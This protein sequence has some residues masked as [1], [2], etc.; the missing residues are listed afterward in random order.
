MLTQNIELKQIQ[1]LPQDWVLTPVI[2]KRP[3]RPN[4]QSEIPLAR[5]TI[6]D[7]IKNGDN[8]GS[9]NEKYRKQPTGVG[10]RFGGELL[11]ID[12]DGSSA[13]KVLEEFTLDYDLNLDDLKSTVSWTSGKE[14]RY[15]LLFNVPPSL[16]EKL[17]N[18]T[19]KV[20]NGYDNTTC[21]KGEQIEF[22]YYR[23]QSVIPPS[24]HPETG[25]YKWI[26]HPSNASIIT[27]PDKLLILAGIAYDIQYFSHLANSPSS[28]Y[29]TLLKAYNIL[30]NP[31]E[32]VLGKQSKIRFVTK[33]IASRL[34]RLSTDTKQQST[35]K[36]GNKGNNTSTDY[37][38]SYKKLLEDAIDSLTIEELYDDPHIEL[39]SNNRGRCPI[40]QG[41]DDN[42]VIDPLSKKWYCHSQCQDGGDVLS[43]LSA[44]DGKGTKVTG[45]DFYKYAEQV[46][47]KAGIEPPP[48]PK[49]KKVE[50]DDGVIHLKKPQLIEFVRQKLDLSYNELTREIHLDGK[51]FD[52]QPDMYLADTFWIDAGVNTCQ[53]A[54]LKVAKENSFHPVDVYLNKVSSEV[55]SMRIDNLATRYF[56]TNE[57]LYDV[58]I[59]KFL[60]GCVARVLDAGCKLDTA[61][62]LQGKQGV[63]KSTFF[64]VLAGKGFFSDSM[65]D[66]SDR[67]DLL[68]AHRCWI[69]E[70]GE[71]DRIFGKKQVGEVKQF[72]SKTED[73]FREPYARTSNTYQRRFVVCGSVNDAQ[74]LTDPTGDRRFWV[75]P[76]ITDEIPNDLLR[77]ERDAIWSAAVKAYKEGQ[78]WW[79]E[80]EHQIRSS[81]NNQQFTIDDEWETIIEEYMS[82][83]NGRSI[84]EIAKNAL[85]IEDTTQLP[86]IQVR[87]GKILQKLGYKKRRVRENG[88]RVNRYY[89][90][91]S[92]MSDVDKQIIED[93]Y[94][95]D[96]TPKKSASK[97]KSKRTKAPAKTIQEKKQ[98]Y[99]NQHQEDWTENSQ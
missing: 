48:T 13:E 8:I 89:W 42:F 12:I 14:G 29:K 22:R 58:F 23:C 18:V 90:D 7:I 35:V 41:E 5:E 6:L 66:G 49:S 63:G 46:L 84:T 34:E 73:T 80:R 15:Q 17:G 24:K 70:W 74:F 52:D 38:K 1:E 97:E 11:A 88:A 16:Q 61:L 59:E 27:L 83:H 25:Q 33:T 85:K 79:L 93:E 36:E 94:G 21:S 86:K 37:F 3:Y 30:I 47:Q 78:G 45:R 40:H 53:D 62:V 44:L 28:G 50:D 77:V 32:I 92:C 96:E 75:I 87:I 69:Q 20:V 68:I 43:Y 95:K 98:D 2:D 10:L 72:L 71:L 26:N 60:I 51:P 19:R 9:G 54:F 56:G 55:E 57:P 91:E 65:G 31:D 82:D 99:V 4:W 64:N 76:I 67:D 81:I 39:K